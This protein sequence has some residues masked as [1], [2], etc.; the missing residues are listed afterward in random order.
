MIEVLVVD[1]M[2]TTRRALRAILDDFPEIRTVGEASSGPGAITAAD[3]LRPDLVLMDVQMPR[4]DGITATRQ[5]TDP[6]RTGGP[7]PVIVITT[8]DTDEHLYGALQAG[9]S[10]FV[11]KRSSPEELAAAVS[12]A[13]RGDTVISPEILPRIVQEA[14]DHR[15]ETVGEGTDGSDHAAPELRTRQQGAGAPSLTEREIS[16]VKALCDGLTNMQIGAALFLD[17]GTVRFYVSQIMKKTRTRNRVHLVVWA[18][19]N[20]VLD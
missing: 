4:G 18:L 8:F 10:G 17:P 13:V 15:H 9:A 16:I 12:A 14:L 20:G 3:A 5:L 11:L 2:P 1:D 7:I 6:S 19:R